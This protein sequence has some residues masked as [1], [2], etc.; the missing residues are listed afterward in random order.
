[1]TAEQPGEM[2]I[3]GVGARVKAAAVSDGNRQAAASFRNRDFAHDTVRARIGRSL[4]DDFAAFDPPK[5]Q[6]RR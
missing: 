6:T 1:M 3:A 4:V 5:D 2:A